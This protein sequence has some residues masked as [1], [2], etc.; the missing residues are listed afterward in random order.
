MPKKKSSSKTPA[1][2][3][4]NLVVEPEKPSSTPKKPGNEIDEI[5]SAKKRKRVEEEV[6][7]LSED[8]AANPSKANINKKKKKN[9]KGPK[10]REFADPQPRPRKKTGDGLIIYTEDELGLGKADAGG[11]ALCP[12]D[13]ECCF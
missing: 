11:T 8:V 10:E 7:K 12:F 1:S 9:N 13:C 2:V 3:P 6:K 5:F 4:K